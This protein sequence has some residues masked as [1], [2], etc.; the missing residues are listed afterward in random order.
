MP[1]AVKNAPASALRPSATSDST[2]RRARLDTSKNGRYS[3]GTSL[4]ALMIPSGK[5]RQVTS[6]WARP[7]ASTSHR[8][9]IQVNGQPG[10]K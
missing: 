2:T 1:I 4:S 7:A 10:S 8:D 6:T 3:S 9:V 5:A